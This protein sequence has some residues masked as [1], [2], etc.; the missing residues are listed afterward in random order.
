MRNSFSK[1]VLVVGLALVMASPLVA[2]GHRGGNGNPG[3]GTGTGT[4]P[5]VDTSAITR[6]AGT[7]ESFTAGIGMGTPTLVVKDGTGKT[8][9][10]VLGPFWFLQQKGFVAQAG[11]QVEVA[12]YACA[13]C[14]GG[15]AVFE[16]R[17][18]TRSL[19]LVLRDALGVPLWIGGQGQGEGQGRNDHGGTCGMGETGNHGQGPNGLGARQHGACA[20]EG[21][22]MSRTTLYAGTVLGF[23]WG[24]GVGRPALSLQTAAAEVT[25]MVSPYRALAVSGLTL[26][27]GQRLEVK[28]APVT[29]DG[30]DEWVAITLKDVATGLE[31]V[32]RDPATGFPVGHR[33]HWS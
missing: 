10:F 17:N 26:V 6:V 20:T 25:I 23:T 12:A 16:V 29:V 3:T 27:P 31:V 21:A 13:S 1:I 18:L 5:Q 14:D 24:P 30:A 8:Y 33:G 7:V 19:T 22:D 32:F 11:D 9:G 2:Q 15:L 28:A 4:G